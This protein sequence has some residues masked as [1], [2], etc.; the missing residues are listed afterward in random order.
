MIL[1]LFRYAPAGRGGQ[2]APPRR[3]GQHDGKKL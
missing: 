2:N 3:P 1:L